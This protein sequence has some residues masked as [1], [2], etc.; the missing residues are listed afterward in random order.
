MA[1]EV[2]YRYVTLLGR[3]VKDSDFGVY[4]IHT[5]TN[6]KYHCLLPDFTYGMALF[7]PTEHVGQK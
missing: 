2:L 5:R 6:I 1:S 4:K 3:V 7:I